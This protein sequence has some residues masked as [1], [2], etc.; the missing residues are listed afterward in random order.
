[1]GE[2]CRVRKVTPLTSSAQGCFRVDLCPLRVRR[3]NDNPTRQRLSTAAILQHFPSSLC[4]PCYDKQSSAPSTDAIFSSRK[5]NTLPKT[6]PPTQYDPVKPQ[7]FKHRSPP[8]SAQ[9]TQ[10]TDSPKPQPTSHSNHYQVHACS[11]LHPPQS[12]IPATN[13]PKSSKT[14]ILDPDHASLNTAP[15]CL[16]T[17]PPPPLPLPPPPLPLPPP[18]L[19][20]PPPP[21]PLP[22][23]PLPLP[24][25]TPFAATTL[26]LSPKHKLFPQKL[27]RPHTNN[28]QNPHYPPRQK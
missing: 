28:A 4:D 5:Q 14:T 22:P 3:K 27:G 1:M 19:P 15:S 21:L 11:M 16:Q 23:P 7:P 12:P 26:T 24:P 6:A 10:L 2:W 9:S 20:L 17:L 13:K 18:P 8:S 25:Q